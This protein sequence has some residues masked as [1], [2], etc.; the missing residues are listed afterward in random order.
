MDT[1]PLVKEPVYQQLNQALRR[2]LRTADFPEHAQ[3]L[4]ERQVCERF[5]V[6]R[7]TANKALSNLVA[8]G[9]LEF[10][11]GVGT[12]VKG[13]PLH[14]DLRALVSFTDK[15]R[16]AAKLP[17]TRVLRFA[18]LPA[19]RLPATLR[20]ALNVEHETLFEIQ[21]LRLADGHPVIL[22]RRWIPVALCPG[23]AR[24]DLVGSL[25]AALTDR[26]GLRIAGAEQTVRAVKLSAAD[27]RLLELP[28]H[29]A[30]LAVQATGLL[31]DG[32]P[33][34]YENTLYHADIYEF[35]THL[36]GLAGTRP[37]GARF[38]TITSGDPC[39]G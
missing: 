31:P 29:T 2:L 12:F 19:A 3:F 1:Q 10:R 24:T 16:A 15:A 32:R 27:A 6:S 34:W 39:H 37:A 25:Y 22:E 8:E 13:E 17:S 26:H 35:C 4:T 5:G 23:L 28:R 33:L 11:K 7:A 21:R 20:A 30:A 38:H 14:Y 36:G 18:R 9:L